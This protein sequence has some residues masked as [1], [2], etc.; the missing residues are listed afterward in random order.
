MGWTHNEH[1]VAALN[2]AD[3]LI[4]LAN[5]PVGLQDLI[6]GAARGFE[7]GGLELNPRKSAT[8]SSAT[9]VRHS[10]WAVAPEQ[11]FAG[12]ERLP[13]LGIESADRYLG[14]NF[15]AAGSRVIGLRDLGPNT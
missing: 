9:S 6:T 12:E 7:R 11:F 13:V 2:Y 15:A 1:Q 8:L 14:L 10:A 4:L 3:D 5:T